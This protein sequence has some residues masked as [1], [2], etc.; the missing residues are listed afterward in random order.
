MSHNIVVLSCDAEASMDDEFGIHAT[1]TTASCEANLVNTRFHE[2]TVS[3]HQS[4]S[5]TSLN[6]DASLPDAL[7][8]SQVAA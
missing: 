3:N 5:V 1:S 2:V 4:V 7:R 6:G 8:L